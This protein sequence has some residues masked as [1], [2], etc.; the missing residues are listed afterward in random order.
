VIADAQADPRFVAA[1]LLAQAEHDPRASAILLT[2][3]KPLAEAVRDE[4]GRQVVQLPRREIAEQSLRSF[5]ALMV[6][7][8][9]DAAIGLANRIAPEHLEL[10]V[11]EP[12]AYVGRIRH[13][14]AIFLGEHTPEPVGDYVAGP[15]H[16][17]PTAGTA[18]FSSALSV[19]HFLKN[20]SIIHYTADAFRKEAADILC[21]ARI[22]GLEAHARTID[23]RMKAAAKRR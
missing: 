14:G 3:A 23:I 18:R 7:P 9:M 20:S 19:N 5:G 21:L 2:D 12:F 22:E 10:Q 1:D 15:N 13:A 11:R 16:V 6:V 8:D 4:L 17:L